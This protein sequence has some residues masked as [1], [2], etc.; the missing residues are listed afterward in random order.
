VLIFYFDFNPEVGV[1][2]VPLEV[3]G[4]GGIKKWMN[5]KIHYGEEVPDLGYI[6]VAAKNLPTVKIKKEPDFREGEEVFISGFPMG[7]DVLRAPGWIHQFSPTLQKAIISA[8]LPMPCDNPHALLLDCVLESGS[9][10]SP[11]FKGSSGELIG[12]V[13]SGIKEP[14]WIIDKR[15]RGLLMYKTPTAHTLAIPSNYLNKL[16]NGLKDIEELKEHKLEG[17]KSI[18]GLI[19]E[20]EKK[21]RL[22]KVQPKTR[23]GI[24]KKISAKDI[25]FPDGF[26]KI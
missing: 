2:H 8:I 12:M 11:V 22:T 1:I 13:Y 19:K 18:K 9:S 7:A 24:A 17:V 3:K 25:E 15:G 23:E 6:R 16:V 10:G 20:A 26:K 5:G 14:Q 4:I 21:G